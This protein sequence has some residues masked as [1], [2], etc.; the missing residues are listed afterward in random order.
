MSSE[1]MDAEFDVAADW[2][3]VAV[4]QLGRDHA[5]P[6][7]CRGSASPSA[8]AWLAEAMELTDGE[9]LLDLGGGIGGPAIWAARR[10]GVRP[11]LVDPMEGACR[12][13]ARLF[14]LPAIRANGQAIPMR[15]ASVDTAWCLGV[16][17]AAASKSALLGE[18]HR[19]LVPSGR[20][21]LLVL[22]AQTDD[23]D[24]VPEGNSFPTQAELVAVLK[25]TGFVIED[26]IDDPGNAPVSWTRLS[27]RVDAL[28]RQQHQHEKAF[29]QEA[30]QQERL[31]HLLS[32]GQLSSQ[33]L[34]VERDRREDS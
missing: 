34:L 17:C 3:R 8:L 6:A 12:S 14:G 13:A 10:Y 33:I 4:E 19:V 25:E 30:E 22:V 9:T 24:D 1:K 27:D 11:I 5:V 28:I 23:L 20:L 15:A 32:T 18:L 21:G 29:R 2:T 26:Q 31:D 16:L 7:A